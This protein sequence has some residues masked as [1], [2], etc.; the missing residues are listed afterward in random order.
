MSDTEISR[1]GECAVEQC[2]R[3]AKPA[4]NVCRTH[5]DPELRPPPPTCDALGR[6]EYRTHTVGDDRQLCPS[7]YSGRSAGSQVIDILIGVQCYKDKSDEWTR[8]RIRNV[9]RKDIVAVLTAA[10]IET[11]TKRNENC[12]VEGCTDFVYGAVRG[13][14]IRS[15]AYPY[16]SIPPYFGVHVLCRSHLMMYLDL[17]TY[18]GHDLANRRVL[19]P[20]ARFTPEKPWPRLR[21]IDVVEVLHCQ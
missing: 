6:D 15:D 18:H 14:P 7:H 2:D 11:H 12:T 8:E 16:R 1:W 13:D 21:D 9:F 10:G 3:D 17:D 19:I 5:A 4:D 20:Q